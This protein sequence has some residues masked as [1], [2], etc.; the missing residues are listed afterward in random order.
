MPNQFKKQLEKLKKE[1]KLFTAFIFVLA[2]IIV[3]ILVSILVTKKTTGITPEMTELAEPLN[4]NLNMTILDRLDVKRT[5]TQ[6]Q[7][8]N[9]PIY[10]LVQDSET[11][12]VSIVEVVSQQRLLGKDPEE[13]TVIEEVELIESGRGGV[14]GVG[15]TNQSILDAQGLDKELDNGSV[16]R[17]V[18]EPAGE[19]VNE[20]ISKPEQT[21]PVN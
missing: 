5:F 13:E 15:S 10:T 8:A 16:E 11:E 3:W 1:K 7:L 12:A 17:P 2:A 14:M 20:P 9:F 4:P 18:G 19:I 6:D 21:V